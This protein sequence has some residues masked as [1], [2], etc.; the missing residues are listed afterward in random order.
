MHATLTQRLVAE[1]LGTAFLLAAIVGSGIMAENLSAEV[2][3]TKNVA[4]EL[5]CNS[6]ATAAMLFVLI[7][8]L[9][10]ISGAHFNPA[11][12]LAFLIRREIAPTT[13]ALFVAAQIVGGLAGVWSTHLMFDE[14][15]FQLAAKARSG[16]PLWLSEAIATFGLV[17]TILLTLKA[18]PEAIPTSVALYITSAYWFTSSTSFANPAVT[19]A[20][21]GSDTFAGIDPTHAPAFIAAQCLGAAVAV[22]VCAFL[23]GEKAGPVTIREGTDPAE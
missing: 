10:P 7:T 9:G 18:R 2:G 16:S 8:M 12:T 11:V 1:A 4:V 20:R 13:A 3:A 23:L 21:A 19:I 14:A 6:V 15:T 22:A 17:A 5:L